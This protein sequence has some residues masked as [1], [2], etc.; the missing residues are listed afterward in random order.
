VTKR[1]PNSS[2]ALALPALI[3]GY[4]T[5]LQASDAINHSDNSEAISPGN[6]DSKNSAAP[7]HK[8]VANAT[9]DLSANHYPAVKIDLNKV[10]NAEALQV[11]LDSM[12]SD[13]CPNKNRVGCRWRVLSLERSYRNAADIS[14]IQLPATNKTPLNS[15]LAPNE[16]APTQSTPS[17]KR[18]SNN[19]PAGFEALAAQNK[20]EVDIYVNKQL[21][22]RAAI[23]FD[24]ATFSFIDPVRL[25]QVTSVLMM[26]AH[27]TV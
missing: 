1:R 26:M 16:A 14:P 17:G 12:A 24:S 11:I 20:S 9:Q 15:D 4:S 8:N 22:T 10:E 23:N 6:R 3:A 21:H 19:V 27:S 13:E 25:T 18:F 7:E 5:P 2:V